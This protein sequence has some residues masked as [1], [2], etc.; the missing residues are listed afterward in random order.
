MTY[1][2]DPINCAEIQTQIPKRILSSVTPGSGDENFGRAAQYAE[3][4]GEGARSSD[5]VGSS[6]L[7]CRAGGFR[8]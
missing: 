1:R 2:P 7:G 6:K 3:M 8:L 4:L 5:E